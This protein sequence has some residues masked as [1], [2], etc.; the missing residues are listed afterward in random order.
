MTMDYVIT[1]DPALIDPEVVHRWLSEE[2]YWAKGRTRE[3]VE[4]SMANS[5]CL[6]ALHHGQLVGFARVVTDLATFAWLCDVFVVAEHRGRGA[7]GALVAAAVAHP[8]LRGLKRFVLA[9]AD[10]HEL[11]RRHGFEILDHP[12][13]WM[14]RRGPGA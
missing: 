5:I 8:E 10:A 12:D 1:E 13:R 7:G 14:M 4:R 11:Y 2:A 9:T 6:G 3:V